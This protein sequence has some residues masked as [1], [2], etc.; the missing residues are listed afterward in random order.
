MAPQT[1]WLTDIVMVAWQEPDNNGAEVTAYTITLKQGDGV[2]SSD[3]VNCDATTGSFN[4]DKV[5]YIP[6]AVFKT[7]PFNLEWGASVFAK[8]IATNIK[9]DSVVSDEGN[10]AIIIYSPDAPTNLLE[11]TSQRTSSTLG[12]TWSPPEEDGG[13]EIIDYRI[14][15]ATEGGPF[16]LL[17]ATS[18]PSLLVVSLS[19]GTN[20]QFI[21]QARNSYGTG[22]NSEPISLLCATVPEPPP[23]PYN[24]R[25]N[26]KIVIEWSEPFNNGSPITGY[27]LFI[28]ATGN[29]EFIEETTECVGNSEIVISN[30]ICLVSLTDTLIHAPFNLQL[31]ESINVKIIAQ[32]FYGDS[33]YSEVGSGALTKLVPDAPINLQND[34]ATTNAYTIAFT[35]TEG[36]SDGGTDVL[37]YDIYYDQASNQMVLL[38]SGVTQL[39]Y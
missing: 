23:D 10:G 8:V 2:F 31:D 28:Q 5:C 37:D 9:G 34:A 17:A 7:E 12:I 4:N 38:A 33:D 19:A 6:V 14:S 27:R 11:D 16:F 25:S 24:Y 35:W 36:L 18:T 13:T 15:R 1:A 29:G 39:F 3:T 22:P 26:D 20:Y 32:N 30:R 21:V